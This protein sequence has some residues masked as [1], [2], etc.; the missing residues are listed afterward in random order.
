MFEHKDWRRCQKELQ[1]FRKCIEEHNASPN[2]FSKK[3]ELNQ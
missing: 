3:S 2:R 1:A